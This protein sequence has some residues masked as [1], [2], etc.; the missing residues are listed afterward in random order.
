MIKLTNTMKPFHHLAV[1]FLLTGLTASCH[2][3]TENKETIEDGFLTITSNG[4]S[5]FSVFVQPGL[6]NNAT[7]FIEDIRKATGATLALSTTPGQD[8]SKEIILGDCRQYAEAIKPIKEKLHHGY[9]VKASGNK[10]FIIGTDNAWTTL[11]MEF[12]CGKIMTKP[13]Y[14]SEGTFKIPDT[15][16]H[17]QDSEDPQLIAS[18]L[19]RGRTFDLVPVEV[20]IC[21]REGDFKVAQGAAS[22]G[23]FV[24]FTMKGNEDSSTHDSD[25]RIYK[26]SLS[27]FEFK[28]VS[29]T[30]NGHHANDMTYDT[31]NDRS[32]V[33]HGSGASQNLTAITTKPAMGKPSVITTTLGIGGL[34]YNAKRDIYGIT[35]GGSKYQT[36]DA[37]FK[38]IKNYGRNDNMKSTYTAQGMGSDDSYVYFPMSPNSNSP[39]KVN[40][41]VVY[42]WDGRYVGNLKIPLTIES[43]SMFYAAG[44]YYVVFYDKAAALYR[45]YPGLSYRSQVKS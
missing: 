35:Q 22:D 21:P 29:E 36:A 41:L 10:I 45:V 2:E 26:Y 24:Y 1:L 42:D 30:F 8:D 9:S 11:G 13:E 44:E 20:G 12:L 34:S 15:F 38:L 40:L 4:K 6:N 3:T 28:G 23:E 17:T 37:S 18:L 32:L 39:E 31:K 33:V 27:P 14:C 19:S 43:E 5:T 7:A 16:S 25:V